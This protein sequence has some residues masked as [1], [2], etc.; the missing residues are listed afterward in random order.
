MTKSYQ[1]VNNRELFKNI[2]VEFSIKYNVHNGIYLHTLDVE[3]I[4]AVACMKTLLARVGEHKITEKNWID[5]SDDWMERGW[6]YKNLK[7]LVICFCFYFR[8]LSLYSLVFLIIFALSWM[9]K[10]TKFDDESSSLTKTDENLCGK[11]FH[12]L[13]PGYV[14]LEIC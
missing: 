4:W 9:M 5:S 13:R 2:F 11:C 7:F 10:S 14:P 1:H 6:N 8:L 12:Y 3:R